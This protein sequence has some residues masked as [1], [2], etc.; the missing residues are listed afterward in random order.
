LQL[1][2]IHVERGLHP[3]DDLERGLSSPVLDFRTSLSDSED[4]HYLF[5]ETHDGKVE[6]RVSEV[7]CLGVSVLNERGLVFVPSMEEQL[8]HSRELSQKA[9]VVK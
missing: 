1:L 8:N 9:E 2:D 6:A 4:A 7:L 3:V 5:R